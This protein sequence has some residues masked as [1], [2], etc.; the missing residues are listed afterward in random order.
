MNQ[1]IKKSIVVMLFLFIAQIVIADNLN[2]IVAH[3]NQIN[4]QNNESRGVVVSAW[5]NHGSY[6]DYNK[7][8]SEN[9]SSNTNKDAGKTTANWA[10]GKVELNPS[11]GASYDYSYKIIDKSSSLNNFTGPVTTFSNDNI[12]GNVFPIVGSKNLSL[13]IPIVISENSKRQDIS[14][15]LINFSGVEI[16]TMALSYCGDVYS[17]VQE[18]NK[19]LDEDATIAQAGNDD[20]HVYLLVGGDN[21]NRSQSNKVA[22][23]NKLKAISYTKDGI[24]NI[25]TDD[26]SSEISKFGFQTIN[27]ISCSETECLI[28]GGKGKL[29][30]YN[31]K[32]FVDL[33]SKIDFN[34]LDDSKIGWS[35]EYW[36]IAGTIYSS[37]SSKYTGVIYKYQDSIFSRI[38]TDEM[39]V[40]SRAGAFD[41]SLNKYLNKWLIIKEGSPIKMYAYDGNKFND[42]SAKI[43]K[44][45]SSFESFIPDIDVAGKVWF[46]INKGTSGHILRFDGKNMVDVKDALSINVPIYAIS[47]A[48]LFYDFGNML[49]MGGGT[50]SDPKLYEV[51][52][53]F[54][55]KPSSYNVSGVVQSTNVNTSTKNILDAYIMVRHQVPSSTSV[56]YY[57][58]NN[59][60][61]MW[62]E[63]FVD[64][65]NTSTKF[66]FGSTGNDL[67]WKAVLTTNDKKV[68]P[69][70]DH[71]SIYYTEEDTPE[72][73][74]QNGDLVKGENDP[75]IFV[76]IFGK[77]KWVETAEEFREKG[78][79]WSNVRTVS[80]E[81]INKYSNYIEIGRRTDILKS[82]DQNRVYRII[83]G[84]RLWIP[85][86]SVFNAQGLKWDE[87]NNVNSLELEKYPRLKLIKAKGDDRIFYVT[88]SG[89]KKH[90]LTTE[91][92]NS[93][94]NKYQ[95]VVEVDSEVLSSL[96][97][98][99]LIK[100][101]KGCKVYKIEGNQKRWIKSAEAFNRNKFDWNKIAPS[102]DIDINA[103]VDAGV[104][105]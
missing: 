99:D 13:N 88:N 47:S 4:M 40:S 89:M 98:V 35:G 29:V 100:D 85:T 65:N 91:V 48:T 82:F 86:V 32:S 60:G 71:L 70:I 101:S 23:L 10:D 14:N 92:F 7:Y 26:L 33:S 79:S 73:I 83:S 53:S 103:Y 9:F 77:K 27:D 87:I 20:T 15:K 81:I 74:L 50:Q 12:F 44:F 11:V 19:D 102:N 97:T 58:T 67:R 42:F 6:S 84:K 61:N 30:S 25:E 75:K 51:T 94:N 105:E 31:G 90:I 78:Y 96:E 1:I 64:S 38:T 43:G 34:T 28:I 54:L 21:S 104:I 68:S 55:S 3:S 52:E 76:I 95:D 41:M 59:G 49:M 24:I 45:Y 36:L 56:K 16:K 8:K 39:F 80:S 5:S 63:I 2:V 37:Q 46:I 66:T 72:I 22:R 93:Y 18:A 57:I 69:Q 17:Y 62:E